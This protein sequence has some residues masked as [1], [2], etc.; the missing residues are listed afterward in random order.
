M[1]LFFYLYIFYC[2]VFLLVV[3]RLHINMMHISLANCGWPF[4][5]CNIQYFTVFTT[6]AL[7]LILSMRV[8]NYSGSGIK[9][10]SC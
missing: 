2:C 5:I 4:S 10:D 9:S 7:F 3:K 6:V 1:C 8:Q